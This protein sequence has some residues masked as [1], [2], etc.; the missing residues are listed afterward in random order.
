MGGHAIWIWMV[1]LGFGACGTS[2]LVSDEK[3]VWRDEIDNVSN[4]SDVTNED[5]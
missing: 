1:M 4:T 5:S 2:W 3:A